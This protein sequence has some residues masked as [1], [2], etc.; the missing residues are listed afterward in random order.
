M[1]ALRMNTTRSNGLDTLRALAITLVFCYH[2][3]VFVSGERTFGWFSTGGWVG[4]DLFFVLSGYLIGNQ[5]F[6]QIL[7]WPGNCHAQKLPSCSL[8][9]H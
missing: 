2:Y 9:T 8:D 1:G 5:V 3:M 7:A 4:V 6:R